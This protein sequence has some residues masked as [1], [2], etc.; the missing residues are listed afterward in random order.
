LATGIST[1]STKLSGLFH[2]LGNEAG[3]NWV[4]SPEL[5]V[6]AC[7]KLKHETPN[8]KTASTELGQEFVNHHFSRNATLTDFLLTLETANTRHH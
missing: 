4:S 3:I 7:M 2:S 1:V 6:E 8:E 5:V